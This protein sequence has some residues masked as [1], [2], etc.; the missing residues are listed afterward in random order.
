MPIT[1]RHLE[2]PYPNPQLPQPREAV[3]EH[4]LTRRGRDHRLV[5]QQDLHGITVHRS[6]NKESGRSCP[7]EPSFFCCG[8]CWV[9]NVAM[10]TL[11][12]P[13]YAWNPTA[14]DTTRQL[15]APG[16]NRH[17]LLFLSGMPNHGRTL[18]IQSYK[19]LPSNTAKV[20][21]CPPPAASR[22]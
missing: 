7:S 6:G 19:I 17:V 9:C 1:V 12:A 11:P 16:M 15:H 21:W 5:H 13:W 4:I 18:L 3:Q 20:Q 10:R 8:Q 22:A 2:L 14:Y